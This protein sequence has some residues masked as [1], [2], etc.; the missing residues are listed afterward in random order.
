[1]PPASLQRGDERVPGANSPSP[2]S[3]RRRRIEVLHGHG[4]ASAAGTPRSTIST[5]RRRRPTGSVAPP[6][7]GPGAVPRPATH[8]RAAATQDERALPSAGTSTSSQMDRR[9]RGTAGLTC[10]P[11][12]ARSRRTAAASVHPQRRAA[13]SASPHSGTSA[14]SWGSMPF[15][16]RE[17]SR[18][19][20]KRAVQR[21]RPSERRHPRR[22]GE[23]SVTA[24]AS[25]GSRT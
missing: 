17:A 5:R 20:A 25:R 9:R 22:P 12:T 18:S 24:P 21:N 19:V 8:A 11:S 13:P 23:A 7:S 6:G 10:T 16:A 15:R 3:W 14:V 1:M 4:S 2:I